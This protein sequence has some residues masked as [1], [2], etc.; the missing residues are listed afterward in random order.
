MINDDFQFFLG[1]CTTK[2]VI[3]AK[4]VLAGDPKQLGAIAKSVVGMKLGYTVSWLERLCQYQL[5]S[6]QSSGHFDR[7]YITQLIK[8]YRSHPEILRIPNELFYENTLQP[9]AKE[10]TQNNL[11]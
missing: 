6:R 8:N 1:L 7:R 10:G 3:H 4:I 11:R 9:M 5:Y 2:R